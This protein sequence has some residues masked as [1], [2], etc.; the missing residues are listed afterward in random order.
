MQKQ[1]ILATLLIIALFTTK[2]EAQ[3]GFTPASQLEHEKAVY[4]NKENGNLYWPQG[5]PVFVRLAASAEEGAKSFLL[6]NVDNGKGSLTKN[7][8]GIKLELSGSQFI[9]WVNVVSK[10]ETK[11]KFFSDGDVPVISHKFSNTPK[12][13]TGGKTFYGKG[14]SCTFKATDK[15]SGVKDL[16]VSVD[17][18]AYSPNTAPINF[19]TQKEVN[20]QYYAVDKVGYFNKPKSIKF[21]VDIEA[22]TTEHLV[23]KNFIEDILSPSTTIKL[24]SNDNLAGVN[25][26]YYKFDTQSKFSVYTG[27]LKLSSLPNGARKITYYSIDN[28]KNE[29]SHKEYAFYHDKEPAMPSIEIAGK[30]HTRAGKEYMSML[31]R[32]KFTA[33]D[34]KSALREIKYSINKSSNYIKYGNPFPLSLK[35]GPFSV[36]YYAV[37]NL[38]NTSSKKVKNYQMDLKPPTTSFKITGPKYVQRNTT[39]WITKET[40]ISLSS[41][42]EGAGLSEINYVVGSKE[43]TIYTEPLSLSEEGNFLCRFWGKDFVGNREGDNVLLLIVDNSAPEIKDIFSVSPVEQSKNSKGD[44]VNVYTQYTSLFLAATD[45]SSGL[46]DVTYSMNGKSYK[47]YTTAIMLDRIGE[48][49]IDIKA[50]DNLGHESRKNIKFKIRKITAEDN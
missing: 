39:V 16:F 49:E 29:E 5:L 45:M 13:S 4:E 34:D 40:K 18:K 6:D 3:T 43:K 11:F 7:A 21:T 27:K 15:L 23:E 17:G 35:S 48:Y 42:D 14:L 1:A 47:K 33:T 28:V 12:H 9:R 10:G 41:K 44:N 26:I 46:K 20:V 32:I 31:S 19:D 37:D 30:Q 36:T 38:G 50:V 2:S 25:K 8:D 24:T 22:P